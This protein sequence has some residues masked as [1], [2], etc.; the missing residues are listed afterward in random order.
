MEKTS[1]TKTRQKRLRYSLMISLKPT[2]KKTM[3]TTTTYTGKQYPQGKQTPTG[4]VMSL[5]YLS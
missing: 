1:Q 2:N 4:L 5:S 3:R